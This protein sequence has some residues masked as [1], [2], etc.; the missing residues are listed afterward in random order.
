MHATSLDEFTFSVD[1]CSTAPCQ[2]GGT[3]SV[4][5]AGHGCACRGEYTGDDC[6]RELLLA[7]QQQ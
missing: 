6:E 7:V 1:P 2:N 5:D 3:C 4:S